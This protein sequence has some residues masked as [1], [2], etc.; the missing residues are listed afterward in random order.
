MYGQAAQEIH[1]MLNKL[2]K[3]IKQIR[4]KRELQIMDDVYYLTGQSCFS[5]FPPSFYHTHTPEEIERI[6]QEELAKIMEIIEQMDSTDK[7]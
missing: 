7:H 2:K 3:I 6:T 1:H 5:L 4:F